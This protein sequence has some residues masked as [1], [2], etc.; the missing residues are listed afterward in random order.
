MNKHIKGSLG[1]L[2]SAILVWFCIV[3]ITDQVSIRRSVTDAID[4]CM[5]VIIPSLFAFMALSGIITS[6]GAYITISKPFFWLSYITGIPK[7]L[8][9]VFII[10][11]I[12]GYP[13]GAKLISGLHERGQID[14]NT[15][16]TMLCFCYGAGPAFLVSVA[17]LALYGN[18]KI[19]ILIFASCALSNLIIASVLCRIKKPRVKTV[20]NHFRITAQML[21]DSVLSA[22]KSLFGICMMI[23]FFSAVVAILDESGGINW[24]SSFFSVTNS[25]CLIKAVLEISNVTQIAKTPYSYIPIISGFCSFGGVCVLFQ[26]SSVVGGRFSLKPFL[27]I[28]PVASLLSAI[29]SYWLCRF[30]LPDNLTA[31]STNQ[32]IFVKVYNFIPSVCLILMIFLLK[33]KKRVAF[34][35]KL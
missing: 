2:I 28:R 24:V 33:I 19:G 27:L 21:N 35:S 26:T 30:M 32:Q 7:E 15:A 22:G 16:K 25:K 20:Q 11:N 10:S 4:R 31:V 29:N 13:V 34:S 23:V 12:A 18:A 1:F 17:G 5:N 8:L 6:S 3:L 9:S 14:K